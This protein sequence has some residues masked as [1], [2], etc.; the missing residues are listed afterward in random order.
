[1]R[2]LGLMTL[3]YHKTLNRI[4][5]AFA[6]TF[7]ALCTNLLSHINWAVKLDGLKMTSLILEKLPDDKVMSSK[8]QEWYPKKS[9]RL[10]F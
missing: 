2:K 4:L 1:M 9:V 3:K 7:S 8:T 5:T 6:S 10:I